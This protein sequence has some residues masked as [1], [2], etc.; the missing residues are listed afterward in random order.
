M[1]SSGNV[2]RTYLEE[3][4][5]EQ[6]ENERHVVIQPVDDGRVTALQIH[7]RQYSVSDS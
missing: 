6:Y 5:R 3:V 2:T 7:H 4:D 1:T